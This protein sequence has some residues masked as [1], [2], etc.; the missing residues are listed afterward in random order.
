MC[1]NKSGKMNTA[2][3][4]KISCSEEQFQESSMGKRLNTVGYL[5]GNWIKMK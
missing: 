5:R 4:K 3:N 1:L 2:Y